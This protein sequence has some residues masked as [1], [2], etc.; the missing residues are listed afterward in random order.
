[1]ILMKSWDG[2]LK[3]SL[4]MKFHSFLML[5]VMKDIGYGILIGLVVKHVDVILGERID[6]SG[7]YRYLVKW[8][9]RSH[10]FDS[11]E[12]ENEIR[13]FNGARKLENFQRDHTRNDEDVEVEEYKIVERVID[14]WNDEEMKET[15]FL[16]KWMGLPYSECTWES[17][18]RI[19]D[20]QMLVDEYLCREASGGIV[21]SPKQLHRRIA[22]RKLTK[23]PEYLSRH[24][25]LRDYQLEGLNWLM[26]SWCHGTN[27]IL[28]D[29]MGLGK[30]IQSISF[31]SALIHEYGF[32]GP[33]LVVVPL[34]TIAAWQHEFARW[35]PSLNT[36]L[37]IGDSRSRGIQRY[38]EWF[39]EEQQD[40]VEARRGCAG[41]FPLFHVLLTTYELVLKDQEHLSTVDWRMLIVDEGHRLKN[42][43]SQLHG[44]LDQISPYSRLL[45]TGTPLQNSMAELWS[46]LHFLM[47]SKFPDY[48]EFL[49]KY[50]PPEG[51]NPEEADRR[52]ERL[53]KMLKPHLLRRMK[54]DVETSLPGKVERILRIELT[55]EQKEL[56]RLIITRNYRE[57]AVNHSKQVGSLNN[58]L[59]ELKKVCNHPLL[60]GE[61]S[62]EPYSLEQLLRSSSKFS[63]LDQLMRRLHTDGHRVLIF[64]QMVRMLDILEEYVKL[65]GWSFQRLDGT[66]DAA[67]RKRSIAAFNS[68][69]S[70]DFVFLLS[71]RAGGLGINLETADTVI[72]YDSD[73]NPQNDL[74]AMARAHRIGQTRSVNIY[75]LVSKGSVEET[76]LERAKR[77]MVLDHLVIQSMDTSARM[78][79]RDDTDGANKKISR[80]ELQAILKFGAQ[81]LFT[82]KQESKQQQLD[83]DEILSRSDNLDSG[84]GGTAGISSFFDQFKVAD[85]GADLAWDDVIPANEVEAAKARIDDEDRRSKDMVLQEALLTTA[86]KRTSR[87]T[88]KSN[89]AHSNTATRARNSKPA[90]NASFETIKIT[91]GVTRALLAALLRYGVFEERFDKILEAVRDSEGSES[92]K[93][94][95]LLH[96]MRVIKRQLTVDGDSYRTS[97]GVHVN[98]SQLWER[99]QFLS[100]LHERLKVHLNDLTKFYITERGIKS[101]SAVGAHRWMI[102]WQT[103]EDDEKLL[104][105]VYRHGFGQWM[106][107]ATDK[108]LGLE[109]LLQPLEHR[110]DDAKFLPKEL[111][112]ARRVENLLMHMKADRP[113][114]G[115]HGSDPKRQ[116]KE[117]RVIAGDADGIDKG[118][119]HEEADKFKN[120]KDMKKLL[121]P[122]REDVAFV[123]S[124]TAESFSENLDKVCTALERIG[125]LVSGG[126]DADR[127]WKYVATCWPTE[128][129]GREL[130]H[131]YN[132]IAKERRTTG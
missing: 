82:L 73:W 121:R 30:T 20:Y 72:I 92:F 31:V 117:S 29:E 16:C 38:Y 1:M 87:L 39:A 19:K 12:L 62:G 100:F 111:H 122:V 101:V 95:H 10:F 5:T 37:Y 99:Q 53:H 105:G 119:G 15:F 76:I 113:S 128:I 35:A 74:Q 78:S 23:C 63:V 14:S 123:A 75:R 103:P 132:R 96:A 11:W 104:I 25:D 81:D 47:P 58:I 27:V 48:E 33:V 40:Q 56:S 71:T 110:R 69:D 2:R 106:S 91:K 86:N 44:V 4:L 124:L 118:K 84:T 120:Q 50:G 85:F 7:H 114:V 66:K 32:T 18:D 89:D 108:E 17:L 41:P 129:S 13:T 55:E 90:S 130:K 52:L 64:S 46:L 68:P 79:R 6:G 49:A 126:R 8:R 28:A 125:Q 80:E 127:V 107:I 94:E 24:G 131:F 59:A 65:R 102:H 97:N 36:L 45:I 54:K 83:L 42:T 93:S 9:N 109:K 22:F 77:K 98:M 67:S 115:G 43:E 21:T 88:N 61:H 3:L 57:L 116:K 26:Y 112:L 34:S 70:S 60:I 51:A